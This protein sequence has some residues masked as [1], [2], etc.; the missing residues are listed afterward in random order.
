MKRLNV[1]FM[2]GFTYLSSFHIDIE[3]YV[4]LF[5]LEYLNVYLEI[6]IFPH[7]ICVKTDTM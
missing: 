2:A 3:R 7:P 5:K 1:S 6:R 4:S